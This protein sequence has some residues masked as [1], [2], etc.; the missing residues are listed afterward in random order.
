MN[1]M[2]IPVRLFSLTLLLLCGVSTSGRAAET[3]NP[4][5]REELTPEH[6]GAE[7]RMTQFWAE[8]RTLAAQE[9]YAAA[10]RNYIHAF[11]YSRGAATLAV[12]RLAVLP[13]E[14]AALA[15]KYPP[16]AQALREE[17][18]IRAGL[19]LTNVA[20]TDEILEFAALNRALDQPERTVQL[21]DQ[22]KNMG[23]RAREMRLRMR[24]L[25][26]DE[27][28]DAGRESE[29]GDAV[30]VRAQNIV[31]RIAA[32]DSET[33]FPVR[34]TPAREAWRDILRVSV[35]ADGARIYGALLGTQRDDM[36]ARLAQR[37]TAFDTRAETWEALIGVAMKRDRRDAALHLVSDAEQKL[38][39]D[40]AGRMRQRWPE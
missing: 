8:A 18:R 21:Y 32:L 29:V 26:T 13:V 31:Y 22:L 11:N 33:D 6:V 34:T 7:Q 12:A 28:I 14:V 19:I 30:I 20:G 24:G 39:K 1:R 5:V 16:A 17:I 15:E 10:V 35:V 36:A 2:P 9:Q 23:D 3:A 38:G 4:P 25:I 27:L 40:V 37:I